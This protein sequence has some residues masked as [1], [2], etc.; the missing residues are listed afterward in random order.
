MIYIIIGIPISA[1]VLE[2]GRGVG[3]SWE[4]MSALMLMMHPTRMDPGRI[5]L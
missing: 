3:D 2:T 5:I 4:R 1:I